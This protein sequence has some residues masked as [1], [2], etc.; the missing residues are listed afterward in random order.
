MKKNVIWWIGVNNKKLSEKYGN[1][2]YFQYSRKTWEYWCEK[3]DVLFVPF[4]EPVEEDLFKYR[5]NWQKAI[6]CFDELERRNIDYDQICLVDSSCMI[7]WDAPNFFELTEHKFTGWVDDDNMR[8]IYDSIQGYK[9]IFNGFELDQEKYISSGF[10]VFNEKHKELFQSFKKLYID[11]ID[12]FCDL[13]DNIVNKG[14]EQTPLNYWLQINNV[15]VKLDLPKAFKLTH[16]HRGG[17]FS[18]NH[19]TGD[20]RP[21]FFIKYGYNWI[22]NGIP[23]DQR[24]QLMG[25]TWDLVKHNYDIDTLKYAHILNLTKHR[26]Q[27]KN[28]T[29][30]KFK[31]DI[32]D[33]FLNDKYKDKV[34]VEIG[35]HQGNST[36][37]LSKIFKKVYAVDKWHI[38]KAKEHCMDC[39]NVEFIQANLYDYKDKNG[40][41]RADKWEDFLPSKVDVVFIDAGHEYYQVKQDIENALKMWPDVEIILDDYGLPPGAVKNAIDEKVKEGVL[42]ID[43]F[44]GQTPNEMVTSG[45]QFI[46]TE[47]VICN[48]NRR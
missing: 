32:L 38:E 29:S 36:K 25:Q 20:D 17:W 1:F 31:K 45:K 14:T 7:K 13:Q 48:V 4:E 30:L 24:N 43:K 23:K 34:L 11:N 12:T 10:I 44:I 33:V 8:W 28:T 40:I 3:N 2:D 35:C 37:Y 16:M 42:T 15:D 47:G 39:D 22:F 5:V 41:H 19:Q 46:D 27:D 26:H 9:D 18:G 6:F 21:P